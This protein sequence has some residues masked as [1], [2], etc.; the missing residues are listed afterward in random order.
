W[1]VD[2]AVGC[3]Y[4]YLNGGPGSP[5]FCYVARRHQDSLVQPLQGWMGHADPFAMGPGYRPATGMRRFLTGTPP[6]LAMQPLAEMVELLSVVGIEAVRAKGI[7][8]TSYAV[9]V[10]DQLL[11]PYGVTVGSPRDPHQRGNHV[12]LQHPRMRE[13]VAGLWERD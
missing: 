10:A 6:V 7:A 4:K 12:L 1:Q 8:L 3:T 2:L 9:E 13:V 5:A 11:A